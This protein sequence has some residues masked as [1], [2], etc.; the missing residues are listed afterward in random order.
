MIDKRNCGGPQ[1]KWV[2]KQ[3][4][5]LLTDE[6]Y[7]Y[8]AHTSHTAHKRWERGNVIFNRVVASDASIDIIAMQATVTINHKL[9][10]Y[11]RRTGKDVSQIHDNSAGV[12]ALFYKLGVFK[13]DRYQLLY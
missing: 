2:I 5:E 10:V 9:N 6:E 8:I 1:Q 11:F 3:L 13:P 12:M 4:F 7:S